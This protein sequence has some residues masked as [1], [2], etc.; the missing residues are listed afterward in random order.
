MTD[1]ETLAVYAAKSNDYANLT[2]NAAD[3]HLTAFIAALPEGGR[4]LDLGC[5]PG[6]SA[7]AMAAAGM[8]VLAT[9]AV[10]EMVALA[11]QHP[12][13]EAVEQTFDGPLEAESFDGIWANFSLLH[14][15]REDMPRL[16][17]HL[18]KAL[19]LGGLFHIGMK[20]G[21]GMHRDSI[22]RLYTYYGEE[23]L[24]G[25]LTDAGLTVTE[26]SH[27]NDIGLDGSRADWI[28]LRAHG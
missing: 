7:A 12:G 28:C 22:G 14:A 26:R 15:P 8:S 1:N 4:A 11:A 20:L 18:R 17:A 24:V 13:V 2:G 5:G 16:L 25:L 6:F 10:A 27:G 19:K 23:E 21:T 3:T 9:D